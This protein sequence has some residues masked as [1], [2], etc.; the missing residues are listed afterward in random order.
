LTGVQENVLRLE[1]FV[2]NVQHVHGA[3]R[4][5]DLESDLREGVEAELRDHNAN[6]AKRDIA[7]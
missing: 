3:E 5:R 1:I 7:N 2:Y 4:A 6:K